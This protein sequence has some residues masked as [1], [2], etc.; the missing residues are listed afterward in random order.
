MEDKFKKASNNP[1]VMCKRSR[2]LEHWHL[3]A[4]FLI[5][6]DLVVGAGSYFVALWLRFDCRFSEIPHEYLVAWLKFAPIYA[7]VSIVVFL[8]MHL[9]QSIWKFASYVELKRIAVSSA[10]LGVFHAVFITFMFQRMP[11]SY[12]LIGISIQF[13]LVLFVRFAYRFIILERSKRT[14]LH[15]K[16]M[17]SRVML[18]GAG[19]AG[20][21]IL[22]DLHN[23]KEVNECVCCIIDDNPN[24]WGRFIDGVP[25]VGGRDDI[26]LNVE[27]YRIE[28]IFL[29]IPSATAEQRR[30]ILDICKETKCELKNLPGVYEFVTGNVTAKS[31]KD[32]AVEDLLGR[33]PIKVNM[34]EIY[35]FIA[36]K[37]IM[38]T[39]GGGSIGSELC[40]QIAQHNPKQLIV[41]DIY[42]NN[43]HAI[44]L[45]LKD[46]FPELNLEVLI[47]S[48]RDSRRINQVF[49]KYKPDVVYHAAA[50][51]HVPLMEDSPCESIKN[52]AIGTYKTAY[53]AMMNGCKR[54]VLIS[55]DKAVNPTNIMGASK[56]LCEMIIQSFDRKIRD[57]KTKDLS[58]L[59]VHTEDVDGSMLDMTSSLNVPRTEFVAVRFGNVLGSN[60]SV[61]PRFKEQIAKGGPVTVTHPDIIRY[62]MTIPEAASLVLQAGTYADG[63]EIFVLDMGFPVK[64]D[65]LARNLI[66]LSGLQPD[67][68]I[69]IS[70]TGLRAGEKLYEEKLMSEEGMRT[71]PNHLIHIGSPIPFDTD[72]FLHQLQMLMTAAYDGQEDTIRNLV[73]EVVKTYHPAGK[74]GSE[75]KGEAYTQQMEI[76]MQKF[77]ENAMSLK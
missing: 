16:T 11:I 2:V 74:H 48:V 47:G 9:Y 70:Y 28:K 60:G 66:R 41:F 39:G 69:K 71:T 45:E 40:R 35:Q 53:A 31:M 12:Y 30:D 77:E 33:D 55:T 72:E 62:F 3:V 19:S 56:R 26:L 14:R 75:D 44:G 52:N 68:D 54:F 64:I 50:H 23:A 18:I 21:L 1:N 22:R 43:A 46:K 32:V 67:V 7:I 25:I 73:A 76:V 63:G 17:A 61:I 57:G 38:V 8:M 49:A 27:K 6:Y 10:I 5:L 51:K 34:D 36:D 58:P 4:A 42:E 37:V 29:A 13:M 65:T 15:Q 59:H 20:Q 24:K